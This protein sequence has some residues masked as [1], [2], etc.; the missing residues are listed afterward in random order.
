M[1]AAIKTIGLTPESDQPPLISVQS[2]SKTYGEDPLDNNQLILRELTFTVSPGEFVIIFGPSGSGKSSLLNL[3][4]GLERPTWGTISVGGQDL[5]RL[6]DE[7]LAS[8][9]RLR[10]G[11]VFQTFNLIKSLSVWEN[12][13]LPQTASGVRYQPRRKRALEL[14]KLFKLEAY[15]NRH[16][17]EISGGEQQRVAIA[18]ALINNP[19]FLLIDEP[20][21][22]LDTKAADAVMQILHGLHYRSKHTIILVTHNPNY[23]SFATRV[24]YMRDGQIQ[25]QEYISHDPSTVPPAVSEKSFQ[26]L[27]DYKANEGAYAMR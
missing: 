18:R 6:T 17:N 5:S 14:L 7:E 24:I 23:L 2:V 4:A 13:A 15:A 11:I 27:A 26:K 20:T 3:L 16:P 9:H 21:G 8:Y 19:Q 12:V 22:N 25:K 1:S 10:M